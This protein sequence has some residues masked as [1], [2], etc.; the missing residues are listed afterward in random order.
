LE[1][2]VARTGSEE[3]LDQPGVPPAEVERALVDLARVARWMFA[4]AELRRLV[5][6]S[7]ARD[8]TAWC[9]D[10]GAGGGHFAGELQRAAR[11]VGARLR[12]LGFDRKLAHLVAGR[13]LGSPQLG[14]VADALVLPL[15]DG[16]AACAFSHLFF[17]H[18]GP[19]RNREVLAEMR[20]VARRVVVLDLRR[21]ALARWLVRPFLRSL[22]LSPIAYHDGVLS[23]QRSYALAEVERVTAGLPVRELR[24]RFPLRWSLVLAGAQAGDPAGEATPSP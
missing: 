8:T 19:D 17:H 18:F 24:R 10:L 15:P 22:R 9:V 11:R 1:A 6:A 7:I 21:S 12:V 16:A 4:G 13:R 5:L 23:V 3:L 14:V 20:R 2:T